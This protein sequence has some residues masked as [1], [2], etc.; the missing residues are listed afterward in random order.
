MEGMGGVNDYYGPA[1]PEM[2][3]FMDYVA[4][5]QKGHFTEVFKSKFNPD[6]R[7][8]LD[9][10]FYS[11][12][13]DIFDRAE[14]KCKPGS[15]HLK[16]V[17][18][19]RIPVDASLLYLYDKIKPAISRK[20]LAE[21]YRAYSHEHIEL[22]KNPSSFDAEKLLINNEVEKYL[23]AEEIDALKK[24]PK[25]SWQI[26]KKQSSQKLKYEISGIPAKRN[27]TV[28]AKYEKNILYVRMTEL[29]YDTRKLKKG[30]QI[31]L[32]DDWEIFLAADRKGD[33]MQFLIDP[34]GKFDIIHKHN[35]KIEYRNI[36]DVK[37]KSTVEAKKWV[38]E[39][40]VPLNNL[41]IK[42]IRYGNF[43]RG[44]PDAGCAWSPTFEQSYGIPAVFG[45]LVF[46]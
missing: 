15:M 14:A 12:V 18:R 37:V 4:E 30:R 3:E 35:G 26:S 16:N 42:N 7:P 21:R 17:H 43:F 13:Q 10:A 44:I 2:K 11:K 31:F 45:E 22:Y 8:W 24:G 39:I 20:D 28:D 38:V 40:A 19:E 46:K 5:R 34:A 29:N 23:K 36:K 9:K 6:S 41:P 32:G 33:Y 1:A 27:L 25:P